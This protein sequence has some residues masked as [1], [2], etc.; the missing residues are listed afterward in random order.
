MDDPVEKPSQPIEVSTAVQAGGGGRQ[1]CWGTNEGD[2]WVGLASLTVGKG[3]R[4]K[5][6][7]FSSPTELT[8][9]PPAPGTVPG[10]QYTLKY[11]LN[12]CLLTKAGPEE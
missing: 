2:F 4:P 5:V 8:S 3:Q 6:L 10:I 1:L 9:V 7:T 11:V 12:K